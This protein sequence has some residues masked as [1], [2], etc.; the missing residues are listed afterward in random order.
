[1]KGV[2]FTEFMGLV[3]SAFG[4]DTVDEIIERSDLPSGGAY[5]AVG[6][7]DH[8]EIV[9][10]VTQLSEVTGKPVQE[11]L[12]HFGAYLFSRFAALYPEMVNTA[13]NALDFLEGVENYIH[14]E[15][16]KLYPNADLP[17][18]DCTRPN[19]N[20]LVMV[21]HSGKHFEDLAG[22]LIEGCLAH[23]GETATV[24]RK[25][26]ERP[27]EGVSFHVKRTG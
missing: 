22:G 12:A 25:N 3:E 26:P 5:T 21:Y 23:F 8:R 19:S 2:I 9:S 11:L 13:E 20:E 4:F 10:L 14:V 15:V 16:R 7:Y 1:M 27:E 24:T 6:T 17:R 18:F